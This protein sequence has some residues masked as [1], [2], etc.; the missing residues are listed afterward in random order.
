[1]KSFTIVDNELLYL[2]DLTIKET[3]KTYKIVDVC[4]PIYEIESCKFYK[5]V[6]SHQPNCAR[7]LHISSLDALR[8]PLKNGI[9]CNMYLRVF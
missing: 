1:L 9:E 8:A 7:F 4:E 3:T 2:R 6:D 5:K